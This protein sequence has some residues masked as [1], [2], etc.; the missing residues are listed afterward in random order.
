[1]A[2]F[3]EILEEIVYVVAGTAAGYLE[4]EEQ[5]QAIRNSAIEH[6]GG[7]T[8][9]NTVGQRSGVGCAADFPE[10]IIEAAR[11]H[12]MALTNATLAWLSIV[13]LEEWNAKQKKRSKR[14]EVGEPAAGLKADFAFCGG[15]AV[16]MKYNGGRTLTWYLKVSGYG[17]LEIEVEIPHHLARNYIT[18]ACQPHI[19]VKKEN[20]ELYIS[21]PVQIEVEKRETSLFLGVDLG[22]VKP[23]SVSIVDETGLIVDVVEPSIALSN[24]ARKIERIKKLM[25]RLYHKRDVCL[26]NGY[27]EKAEAHQRELD[28]QRTA[29]TRLKA[30]LAIMVGV[31]VGMIA[32][33]YGAEVAVENLNFAPN[34]KW[35][36]KMC[37]ERIR[38]KSQAAGVSFRKVG[39]ANTSKTCPCGEEAYQKDRD[40]ICGEHG[41]TDR[42]VAAGVEIARRGRDL[43]HHK[44]VKNKPKPVKKIT[45]RT[46]KQAREVKVRKVLGPA[47][48]VVLGSASNADA[49]VTLIGSPKR[50]SRYTTPRSVLSECFDGFS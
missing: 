38:D 45:P 36:H 32:A 25:S 8:Q 49:T 41:P 18:K 4:N 5:S 43:K 30:E 17:W 37:Q 34:S 44:P 15:Q 28:I 16:G 19:G 21:F 9:P 11:L 47:C 1:M 50:G 48:R 6:R 14:V 3:K 39:A 35:N 27:P 46:F 13:E 24:L 26:R 33:E 23:Y 40:V 22:V 2:E 29:L 12:R 7:R 31:E 10:P 42:D 20:G